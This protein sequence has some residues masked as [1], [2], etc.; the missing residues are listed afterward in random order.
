MVTRPK[1]WGDDWEMSELDEQFL[2]QNSV[3][4]PMAYDQLKSYLPHRYP[5]MLI[6]RVTACCPNT[7]ITGYKNVSINEPFFQGHFPEEPIMPGV[8][9]VEALAQ[10]SGILAF[11]SEGITAEDGYLFLFAGVDKVRFKNPVVPGDQLILKSELIL[12]KRNIYKFDCRA[13]VDDKLAA[14]AQLMI[15][16][17]DRKP[18]NCN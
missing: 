13:Y 1:G 5:F 14:N 10:L 16:R 2:A 9:I 11:V 17:Q 4:M 18:R 8:L 15:I 7:W 12:T 6:D 3:R